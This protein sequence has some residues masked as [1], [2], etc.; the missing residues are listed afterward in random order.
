MITNEWINAALEK[1]EKHVFGKHFQLLC[2]HK[3]I[4]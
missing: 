4:L 1:D 3:L 2:L